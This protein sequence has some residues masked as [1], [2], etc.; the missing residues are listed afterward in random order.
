M[1]PAAKDPIRS[2]LPL[3]AVFVIAALVYVRFLWYG[4]I[5][6][7]D[8]EMVFSNHDVR[9]FSFRN[10][11][12]QYYVGNYLPLTMFIHAIAFKVFGT[13]AG[14]HHLVSI[15]FH[16]VNGF[17]V[18]K[19]SR[20]FL[21]DADLAILCTGIFLLHPVQLES[22]GWISELK[23]VV[24][25][26]FFLSAL[27]FYLCFKE[28]NNKMLYAAC[29]ASFI[30]A[31]LCKPSAIVLPLCLVCIDL[32]QPAARWRI[33]LNKLPLL[34]I[35][36]FF[37]LVTL[38]AQA[39]HQF[40]N[41]SHQFPIY[42]RIGMAGFAL[43]KYLHLFL[44]PAK[45]SVIYPYPDVNIL[46]V[47]T[48]YIVILIIA[49]IL[50]YTFKSGKW[51]LPAVILFIL[52]NFILVLQLVP[53]GEALFADRY[54]Y[55]PVVGLSW[56]LCLLLH[57][58]QFSA[59]WA[60]VIILTC[61]AAITSIRAAKWKDAITLYEDII[62]KYPGQFVALN[63]AG[64]ESMRLNKDQ[65]ALHYFSET[66]RV[67]PRNYKGHYNSGLLFIKMQKPRE[68][69]RCFNRSI[70][71]YD[72]S[73]AYAGRATAYLMLA[74]ADSAARD[75]AYAVRLDPQ[76]ARAHFVLANS[77]HDQGD[78]DQALSSYNKAIGLNDEDA[79]FYFKRAIT[80]G[81]LNNFAG[82]LRDLEKCTQIHPYYAEAY[83]WKGVAKVNLKQNPCDDFKVAAR[84]NYDPAIKAYQK[85]CQ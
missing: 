4:S 40:I 49:C 29:L 50:V 67:A 54:M 31:C 51:L 81:K 5:S 79:D 26:T 59:R 76:N 3:L 21:R 68:A 8:P 84:N 7:D 9:E 74:R 35:S 13:F 58:L 46:N 43:L 66:V 62:R 1:R 73:K 30:F 63:S 38:D 78:L 61:L 2:Y 28:Q 16:L 71:L 11:F 48:G 33:V 10:F 82:S 83:Y 14:G 52:F 57:Q 39:E 70:A 55:L 47:S 41:Y 25:A 80:L 56:L 65:A 17:F 6:W 32:M 24:S 45:L 75:A 18:Y 53:F 85:F 20:R 37:G 36:V 42:Q 15:L 64:V 34:I 19:L 27:I 72:Y 60:M 22:V 69:I 44:F 23:T 12:R 77:R